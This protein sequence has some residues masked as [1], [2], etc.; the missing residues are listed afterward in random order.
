MNTVLLDNR[1]TGFLACPTRRL[2]RIAMPD[3]GNYQRKYAWCPSAVDGC[4]LRSCWASGSWRLMEVQHFAIASIHCRLHWYELALRGRRLSQIEIFS[5]WICKIDKNPILYVFCQ[6]LYRQGG[7]R[8]MRMRIAV[9][10]SRWLLSRRSYWAYYRLV[11][12]SDFGSS[13]MTVKITLF[14]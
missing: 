13:K 3:S 7:V 1:T 2:Q 9:V 5:S 4:G 11:T 10:W 12:R 14:L 8:R 6:F